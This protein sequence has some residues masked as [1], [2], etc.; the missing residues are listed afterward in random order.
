MCGDLPA[1]STARRLFARIRDA[2]IARLNHEQLEDDG[3]NFS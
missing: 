1:G 2:A 3:M